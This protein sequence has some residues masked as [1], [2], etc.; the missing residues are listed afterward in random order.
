MKPL[1]LSLKVSAGALPAPTGGHRPGRTIQ[2]APGHTFPFQ[3]G[4]R[5]E[6]PAKDDNT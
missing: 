6:F 4:I 2:G 3:K 1:L 5:M